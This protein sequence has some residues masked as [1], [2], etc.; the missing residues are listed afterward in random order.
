MDRTNY[1]RWLPVHV[2]DMVQLS[3]KHP[4]IHAEFLQGNFFV[5]KSPHKFGLFA[6]DQA[7]EQSTKILQAHG[8]AVGLYEN[9]EA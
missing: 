4:T 2:C 7:H 9:N 3:E 1:A 8:G 6:K 5:K